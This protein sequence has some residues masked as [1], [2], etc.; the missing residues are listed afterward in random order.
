MFLSHRIRA[1]LAFGPAT[2]PELSTELRDLN[3]RQ[4]TI[5]MWVLTSSGQA[6]V[7]GKAP[8][9]AAGRGQRKAYKLYELTGKG[10]RLA[11]RRRGASA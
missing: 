9:A 7:V 4:L 6:H 8:V 2:I 1:C 5:G 11:R 10:V 3:R